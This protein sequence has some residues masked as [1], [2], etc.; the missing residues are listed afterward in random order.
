MQCNAC[1]MYAC[2][3]YTHTLCI[4]L[5]IYIYTHT[6]IYVHICMLHEFKVY[7]IHAFLGSY[8]FRRLTLV[9]Q[10]CP[11]NTPSCLS[12]WAW[13]RL[14]PR[15]WVHVDSHLCY[16]AWFCSTLLPWME[17]SQHRSRRTGCNRSDQCRQHLVRPWKSLWKRFEWTRA[18]TWRWFFCSHGFGR[19]T[20]EALKFNQNISNNFDSTCMCV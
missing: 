17:R 13:L 18:V 6:Y 7:C 12:L 20:S 1:M 2:V 16:K 15:P 9:V 4:F 3:W 14:L 10:S 5:C 11:E 8:E 19:G